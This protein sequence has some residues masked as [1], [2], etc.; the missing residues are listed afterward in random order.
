MQMQMSFELPELDR[1]RT[2]AAVES[3]LEKY[4]IFKTIT[5][6]DREATLTPGYSDMPR[7][8]TGTVSDQTAQIAIHNVEANKLRKEYCE[9]V[10]RAVQKLDR[11]G[12]ILITERYMGDE[13]VKDYNVYNDSFNP[14]L[15]E[16]TYYKIKWRAFYRLALALNI[17]VVKGQE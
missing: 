10:E 7:S 11:R 9:R 13:D 4:R 6:D 17:Q 12:R 8:N 3:A 2:Q 5:L 15:G 1:K 14:P 16:S